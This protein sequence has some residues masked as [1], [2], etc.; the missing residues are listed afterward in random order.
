MRWHNGDIF[1]GRF[2]NGNRENGVMNFANGDCYT[3]GWLGNKQHGEG[4]YR[5]ACKDVFE[6]QY[7]DGK[8]VG[9]GE[10]K[11]HTGDSYKGEFLND[12]Y[13]GFGVYT[14]RGGNATYEGEYRAGKKE[15]F[16]VYASA[17]GRYEGE[18]HDGMRNGYGVY[19]YASGDK[20]FGF[21]RDNNLAEES[22]SL[23]RHVTDIHNAYVIKL[24][25]ER[26][27]LN[28]KRLTKQNNEQN[29]NRVKK[30]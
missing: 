25:E 26:R 27:S 18:W 16:G 13:E 22:K 4:K 30:K 11:C 2:T 15:G 28:A 3:G 19:K 12:K 8:K 23:P 10:Y 29:V 9:Y 14:W 5:Y 20:I 6:G 24:A 1:K 7:K 17:E 21:W